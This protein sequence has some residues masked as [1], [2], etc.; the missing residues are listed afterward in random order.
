MVYLRDSE[1]VLQNDLCAR[2]LP[3]I[4]VMRYGV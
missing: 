2:R 3:D 1:R 4:I